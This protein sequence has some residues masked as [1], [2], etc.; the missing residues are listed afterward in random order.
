MTGVAKVGSGS[1]ISKV[2]RGMVGKRV[3]LATGADLW[4]EVAGGG[5]PVVLIHGNLLSAAMWEPHIP[6]L[7]ESFAVIAPMT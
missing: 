3:A 4:V 7:A 5:P 2:R 1:P 6:A